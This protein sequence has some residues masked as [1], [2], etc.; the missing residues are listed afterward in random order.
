QP[1]VFPPIFEQC[2]RIVGVAG[3]DDHFQQFVD[4][5]DGL[6]GGQ[7]DRFVERDNPAEGGE[8]IPVKR[9]AKRG[10]QVG[11]RG[12]AAGRGVFYDAGG[13]VGEFLDRRERAV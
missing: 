5:G 1:D 11:R 2:Q 7:V 12:A 6:R 4:A 9:P 10:G 3:G 8:R 13:G